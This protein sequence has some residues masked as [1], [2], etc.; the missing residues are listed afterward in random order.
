[1]TLMRLLSGKADVI[2][3]F[4]KRCQDELALGYQ[5]QLRQQQQQQHQYQQQYQPQYP[6]VA[7]QPTTAS[8]TTN[9]GPDATFGPGPTPVGI[10]ASFTSSTSPT[11]GA[12]PPHQPQQAYTG[13][14]PPLPPPPPFIQPSPFQTNWTQNNS[15]NARPRADIALYLGDIQDHII[16]MFQNLLAYEKIFSRS[17]SNYLAQLQVESFNSNNK[18]SEMFSKVTIIG[19]MLVP[20]N[21]VTGMFG[22]NVRVPGEQGSIAW[23]FGI[24]GVLIV[25]IIVS[26]FLANWW[27]KRMNRKLNS[28][29]RPVFNS[30]RSIRS[31][32]L[33]RHSAK[34]II[35]FPNKYD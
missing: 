20:L 17:H 25:V 32:G 31:L 1:M 14:A 4:A 16:T 29:P 28:E 30:R 15:D 18:I 8:R 6:Y 26:I 7:P 27:L 5:K 35:S 3:M 9:A 11:P 24:L 22:M 33:K 13:A 34:S 23:F 12:Q 10:G 2:K 21:L 19:T